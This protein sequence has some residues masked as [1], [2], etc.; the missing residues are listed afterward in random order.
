MCVILTARIIMAVTH[1]C[2]SH[3]RNHRTLTAQNVLRLF[4]LHISLKNGAS[5][6]LE[7]YSSN[8]NRLR[9]RRYAVPLTWR[10]L[11]ILYLHT[12]H[13]IC[14]CSVSCDTGERGIISLADRAEGLKSGFTSPCAL[15]WYKKPLKDSSAI[16]VK[17][18]NA[19][20]MNALLS[21][22][23]LFYDKWEYADLRGSPKQYTRV[24]GIMKVCNCYSLK[25]LS[26]KLG[27][28]YL[29]YTCKEVEWKNTFRF[30]GSPWEHHSLQWI[31][32]GTSPSRA[33]NNLQYWFETKSYTVKWIE[34]YSA[35]I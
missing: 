5:A 23:Q 3:I 1:Q 25:I 17:T 34:Q 20:T 31:S 29:Q 11:M 35:F 10:L 22:L 6:E 15:L 7:G 21:V 32:F 14:I 8:L 26:D 9:G 2:V 13:W 16:E 28:S 18:G 12:L 4:A 27:I 33:F 30:T 24:K 19:G